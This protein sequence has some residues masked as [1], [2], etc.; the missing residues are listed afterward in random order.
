VWRIY[1]HIGEIQMASIY[2]IKSKNGITKYYGDITYNGNRYRKCL[3]TN[4]K[5]AL[6]ELNKFEHEIF[7]SLLSEP[8]TPKIEVNKAYWDFLR[9]L[10]LSGVKDIKIGVLPRLKRFYEYLINIRIIY[11]ED[12]TPVHI[13]TFLNKRRKTRVMQ[14]TR[15]IS[16]SSVNREIQVIKR[17][18]SYCV[19]M[20]MIDRN[21][22]LAIQY[23]KKDNAKQRFYFSYEHTRA[24]LDNAEEFRDFLYFLL[25][26]GLRPTDTFTLKPKHISNSYLKLQMNKTGDYLNIPLSESIMGIIRPRLVNEF[27]F[28]EID[29]SWNKK[30]CLKNVRKNFEPDYVRKNNINLHTFRH[31]YAHNMLNKGVPKEVLQTL[32]GH[33]S[34]KTTEIYANWVRKEELERWV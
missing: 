5:S 3:A 22:A 9:N 33:R 12:I 2:A 1:V 30:Q 10:E 18:L 34:I 11:L 25:H 21:P 17:F 15:I 26:T 27:I 7:T 13:Q 14:G 23:F 8:S 24:I 32:L 29:T 28:P 4:K 20:Q 6:L 19:S 16:T 31:T